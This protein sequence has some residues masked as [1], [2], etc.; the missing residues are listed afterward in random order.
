MEQSFRTH[1]FAFP[2]IAAALTVLFGFVVLAG[3]FA[4]VPLFRSIVPGAVE[5]KANTALGLTAAGTALFI[6][7]W[8]SRAVLQKKTTTKTTNETKQNHTTTT[9]KEN[10]WNLAIDELLF[11]DTAVA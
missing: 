2:H 3:W 6:L 10:N 11:R 7:N 4:D 5:M 9:E 1:T 8:P